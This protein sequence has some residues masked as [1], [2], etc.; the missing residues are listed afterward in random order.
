MYSASWR[1][2]AFVVVV[3]VVGAGLGFGVGY[4]VKDGKTK[5]VKTAGPANNGQRKGAQFTRAA[6]VACIAQHGVK[7]PPTKGGPNLS[8]PPP[9]VSQKTYSDAIVACYKQQRSA[10]KN[11]KKKPAAKPKTPATT[12]S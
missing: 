1:W 12:Q 6:L 8:K 11:A 2:V 9:G 10:A 5:T 4:A 7:Y 3:F